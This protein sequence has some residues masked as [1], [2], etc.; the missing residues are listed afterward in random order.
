MVT[1]YGQNVDDDI[2]K[3][4]LSRITNQIFSISVM[5]SLIT[6]IIFE[7]LLLI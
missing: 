3:A 2:I 4:N 5:L 6:L 7:K 1:K